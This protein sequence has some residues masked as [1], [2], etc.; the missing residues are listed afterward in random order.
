MF[1]LSKNM[2]IYN[3]STVNIIVLIYSKKHLILVLNAYSSLL[4][5]LAKLQIG[6]FLDRL[7]GLYR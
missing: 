5:C 2:L 6:Y 3:N 1:K 4:S 7:S